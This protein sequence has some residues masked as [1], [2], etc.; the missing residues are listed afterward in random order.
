MPMRTTIETQ[1]LFDNLRPGRFENQNIMGR[2]SAERSPGAGEVQPTGW[3]QNQDAT[4]TID[5]EGI[6]I[7]DGA[8]TLKDPS[9]ETVMTGAGFAGSWQRFLVGGLYNNNFGVVLTTSG[10]IVTPTTVPYWGSDSDK[11]TITSRIVTDMTA[12]GGWAVRIGADTTEA[13]AGL[14][15]WVYQNG[16]PVVAG[17]AYEVTARMIPVANSTYPMRVYAQVYW[18]DRDGNTISDNWSSLYFNNILSGYASYRF[19]QAEA[20]NLAVTASVRI[21]VTSTTTWI[22][23]FPYIMLSEVTLNPVIVTP[24]R[25]MTKT[26]VQSVASATWTRVTGYDLTTINQGYG[27][28]WN[29]HG[30]ELLVRNAGIYHL[31]A[32]AAFAANATNDRYV[33]MS[34]ANDAVPGTTPDLMHRRQRPPTGGTAPIEIDT[35]VQLAAQDTF[36][37]CV[38]QDSGGNLNL[39]DAQMTVTR[40]G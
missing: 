36:L 38:R 3:V 33:G 12:S 21:L 31:N 35:I 37:L 13:D 14:F 29:T 39:T 16:V 11:S 5:A 1:D 23:T 7:E 40:I 4:V 6:T 26:S 8:L 25:Q 20:P 18:F 24:V 10:S 34:F 9:G 2:V 22:D 19:L 30:G 27:V 28:D 32:K 15:G 17:Q